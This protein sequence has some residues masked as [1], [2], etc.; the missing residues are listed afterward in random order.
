MGDKVILPV[1]KSVTEHRLGWDT[2]AQ[3]ILLTD[4]EPLDIEEIVGFAA[5]AAR[6]SR[7]AFRIFPVVI[8]YADSHRLFE[9][10]GNQD[11]GFG[12]VTVVNRPEK[13]AGITSRILEGAQLPWKFEVITLSG[14]L[15]PGAKSDTEVVE[16]PAQTSEY[17]FRRTA[18]IQAPCYV[19]SL[20]PFAWPTIFFL[21]QHKQSTPIK[22]VTVKATLPSGMAAFKEIQVEY[23]RSKSSTIHQL[24]A[25][26]IMLDLEAGQSWTHEAASESDP[27][28]REEAESIGRKWWIAGKWASFVAV[29][30]DNAE[31]W[32]DPTRSNIPDRFPLKCRSQSR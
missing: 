21:F 3:F 26:A 16:H 22:G 14:Y 7:G 5:N 4:G 31:S 11:G 23:A 10:I 19:Y 32:L 18:Y 25:K 27:S 28:K 9:G 24:A 8:R 12:E 20:N 29:R 6:E 2:S 30:H 15:K 1:L 17:S 13:L